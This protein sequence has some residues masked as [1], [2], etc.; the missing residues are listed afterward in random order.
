[1]FLQRSQSQIRNVKDGSIPRKTEYVFVRP[2][3]RDS[4]L[5]DSVSRYRINYWP[6]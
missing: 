5:S 6:C 2:R 3:N 1:M 4:I